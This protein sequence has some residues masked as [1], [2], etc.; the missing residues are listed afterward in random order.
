MQRRLLI[1][2][3]ALLVSG[4]GALAQP[5]TSPE[6][7]D[8]ADRL[9]EAFNSTAEYVKPSVVSISSVRTMEVSQQMP[10]I[11]DDPMFKRFFGDVPNQQQP[12]EQRAQAQ[13]TGFI[14]DREGHIITNNHV[15]ENADT[16]TVTLQDEREYKAEIVGADPQTD[17]AVIQI[18]AD[19]LTPVTFGDSD[20]L[21]TGQW[22][23]A[24]GSPFGLT[25]SITA[26]IVSATGRSRF[27]IADY[28][29]FIQ[30]DAAINPGN[31]GGPLVDLRGRVVGM[32]TAIFS[33]SGGYN[34]I[35]FAI[36]AEIIQNI[37]QKLITD[38]AVRRGFLGVYIQDLNEGLARSFGF[39][40]TDGVL[41]SSVN[42]AGPADKAGI[43]DGDI[44]TA[45]DNQ[46]VTRSDDLRL[47]VALSD[48]GAKLRFDIFR[49]GKTMS[50]VVSIGEL[51][52]DAVAS[53]SGDETPMQQDDLGAEL[54]TLTPDLAAQLELDSSVRGVLVMN[55][56]QF[57]VA[58]NSGLRRG[59]VITRV[60][61]QG[62]NDLNQYR[63]AIADHD[64]T[65][66]VRLAVIT[67]GAQRYIWLQDKS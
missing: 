43:R 34:G 50:K 49:D 25:S 59:D 18:K 30:T 26:G 2:G 67:Q 54:R 10:D 63:R 45:I 47:R 58:W 21:K 31:S 14:I 56:D 5:S 38:G 27:G 28:E 51:E 57:S 65:K 52:P 55:V 13:G 46:P 37:S 11:F 41:V 20:Q 1:A 48:P 19:G 32:N 29:D 12:R 35:G 9:T 64:L 16:V 40:G 3:A 39:E 62:V 8:V 4:A 36:P 60:G 61:D 17:I 7:L 42:D 6:A 22:V 33:R 15:V 24:V 66:G 53:A 23:V 44:I